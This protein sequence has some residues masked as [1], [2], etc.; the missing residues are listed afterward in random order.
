MNRHISE[1]YDAELDTLRNRLMEMGGT[2]EQQV[3]NACHAL[4]THNYDLGQD[5]RDEDAIVNDFEVE[6]DDK[7][8]QTIAR[9]QPAAG[10]LRTLICIMKA[11]T[12]LERVGDE[13]CRIAKTAQAISNMAYPDNQYVELRNLGER[14][15]KILAGALD[16]FARLDAERA[17]ELIGWDARI[18]E[19]YAA[20]VR[21][22][23]ATMQKQPAMAEH[24][25]NVIWAARALERIG[26][27]AKNLCEYVVYLVH[28]EDVR[29]GR[30]QL[31]TVAGL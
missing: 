13:A 22:M 7:C 20:I 27:H 31:P 12:D 17:Q 25:V 8:I 6:L 9:R 5:V 16:T 21:H 11:S 15:T 14:V 10:D 28:G 18:D 2:V 1:Q 29:H 26:D 19:G 4:V 3:K 30:G 23:V 24:A